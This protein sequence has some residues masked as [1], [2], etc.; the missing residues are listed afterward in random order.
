MY[1]PKQ[2]EISSGFVINSENS[3]TT[4]CDIIIYDKYRTPQI[5]SLEKQ[6]FFPIETVAAVGEVKSDINSA[7]DINSYLEKLANV[8]K[9]RAEIKKPRPYYHPLPGDYNPSTNPYDNVFTFLICKKFN[10][11]TFQN[12]INYNAEQKHKHNLVLSLED[13]LI[14][15]NSKEGKLNLAVS[16]MGEEQ[17]SDGFL[18]ND[19]QE[20]PDYIILFLTHIYTALTYTSLLDIDITYYL[21]NKYSESWS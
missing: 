3:I 7:A 1:V 8:K 5:E 21:T 13:G 15:Y 16:F 19:G 11:N 14:S 4:Q 9:M 17:Y 10:F 6:K 12:F 2:F 18:R 20:L